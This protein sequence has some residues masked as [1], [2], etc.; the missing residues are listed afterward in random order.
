MEMRRQKNLNMG[1][2]KEDRA[3]GTSG[4]VLASEEPH[5]SG[6]EL[7]GGDTVGQS[8]VSVVDLDV[9]SLAQGDKTEQVEGV[10]SA[11]PDEEII[12]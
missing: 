7:G 6:I 11:V 10:L 3:N 4:P 5:E 2:L 12:D 1:R 8:V 9:E